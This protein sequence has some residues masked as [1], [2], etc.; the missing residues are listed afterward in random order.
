MITNVHKPIM[1]KEISSFLNNDKELYAMESQE[2]LTFES[3]RHR[4][5][6]KVLRENRIVKVIK[7]AVKVKRGN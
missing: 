4:M 7:G 2:I 6:E 1:V 3:V 5:Y